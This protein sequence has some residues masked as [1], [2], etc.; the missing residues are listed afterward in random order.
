MS[1]S[2]T[3]PTTLSQQLSQTTIADSSSLHKPLIHVSAPIISQVSE[4]PSKH[5]FIVYNCEDSECEASYDT[6]EA[7][8]RHFL[9][10]SDKFFEDY[11]DEAETYDDVNDPSED[12]LEQILEQM[13]YQIQKVPYY[14]R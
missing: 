4:T 8:R 11:A 13:N 7:A 12:E 5:I 14:N 3:T 9:N 6:H 10:I 1:A 2:A